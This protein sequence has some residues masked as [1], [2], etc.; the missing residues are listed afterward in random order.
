[1]SF[2]RS[3]KQIA[4]IAK[5]NRSGQ[6]QVI[7]KKGEPVPRRSWWLEP[8]FYEVAKGEAA[9][10]QATGMGIKGTE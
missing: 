1:M 4:A 7:P 5:R 3:P 2:K 8:N 10:I 9:R 6:M